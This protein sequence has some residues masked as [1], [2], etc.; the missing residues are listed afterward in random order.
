M[1]F[2]RMCTACSLTIRGVCPG[3]VSAQGWCL[4]RGWYLPREMG[5]LPRG[6]LAQGVSVGGV[7]PGVSVQGCLSRGVCPGVSAQRV[8]CLGVV[9]AQMVSAQGHVY[10]WGFCQGG[11][12]AQ[13]FVC[14]VGVP[15]QRGCMSRRGDTNPPLWTDRHL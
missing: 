6:L 2:S 8:V 14:P 11:M 3:W 13:G 10:P 12:S 1:H 7:C 15:S 9:S 4:P 5:C